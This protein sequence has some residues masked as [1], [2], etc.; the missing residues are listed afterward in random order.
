GCR[1]PGDPVPP[2]APD[3]RESDAAKRPWMPRLLLGRQ[4]RVS[5]RAV[6]VARRRKPHG[7]ASSIH[8]KKDGKRPLMTRVAARAWA[9]ALLAA[10]AGEGCARARR[11]DPSADLGALTRDELRDPVTCSGCHPNHFREWSSSMHA[12]SA[13]DP[14]FIAMNQRGQ[15]ETGGALGDFCVRCHAPMAVFDKL[16]KDGLN[17]DRLPDKERG[18]SCYFCHDIAGVEGD[19]NAM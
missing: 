11:A 2:P 5:A 9:V 15:R 7:S 1:P 8:R 17:L 13:K 18:V 10:C 6:P 19:H 4:R 12:Y 16:S 14:V 3:C